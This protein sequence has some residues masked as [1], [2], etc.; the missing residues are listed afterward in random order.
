MAQQIN[1]T[2]REAIENSIAEGADPKT[3][4]FT[5][6]YARQVVAGFDLTGENKIVDRIMSRLFHLRKF[7]QKLP[8]KRPLTG[9]AWTEED[10][11]RMVTGG[12]LT[13]PDHLNTPEARFSF[14]QSVLDNEVVQEAIGIAIT[15]CIQAAVD[16]ADADGQGL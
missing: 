5:L 10:V 2:N 6:E 14:V 9:L 11:E 4:I 7:V 1:L 13:L 12:S 16:A 8:Q 3:L 15:D